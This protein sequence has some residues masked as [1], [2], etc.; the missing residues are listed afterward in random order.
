MAGAGGLLQSA[1]KNFVSLKSGLSKN[2]SKLEERFKNLLSGQS[3][4]KRNTKDLQKELDL[5]IKQLNAINKIIQS[6]L[7]VL[8]KLSKFISFIKTMLTGLLI[9]TTILKVLPIPSLYTIVGLSVTIGDLLSKITFLLKSTLVIVAGFDLIIKFAANSLKA[10]I[11]IIKDI[12]SKLKLVSQTLKACGDPEKAALAE[13]L[14]NAL[15]G[16]EG[17]IIGL[18]GD[19]GLGSN[20]L[21]GIGL[22]DSVNNLINFLG[23]LLNDDNSYK[24]FTFK[25]IEEETTTKV[26]AKRRY[27]I[28]LNVN[29]ILVLTGEPSY[30]TDTQVLID[31]L[32]LRID[33][34]NLT[35]F[36]LTAA[37][38]A[39]NVSNIADT[40]STNATA[41]KEFGLDDPNQATEIANNVNSQLQDT[42]NS[43]PDQKNLKDELNSILDN[44]ANFKQL[45]DDPKF[46]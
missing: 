15:N 37:D 38:I 27:A 18:N 1:I 34:G 6:I 21:N 7:N 20:Q 31:E 24:G 33:E 43:D 45:K 17:S 22:E 28:A 5:I 41:M 23:S 16:S 40:S 8:Q 3:L 13:G 36:N 11:V 44:K 35:G 14:D 46:L 26:I 9:L 30:A 12:I 39:G 25:I 19:N 10:L 4:C 32:K 42:I 2:V 29:G